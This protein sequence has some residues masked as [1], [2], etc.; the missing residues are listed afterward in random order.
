MQIFAFGHSITQG[1]WDKE[2]GWVQRLRKKLDSRSLEKDDKYYEVYNLGVSGDFTTDLLK[3]F[4]PE[5]KARLWEEVGTLIILQIGANDSIY[6]SDKDRVAVPEEDFRQNLKQL[7]DEAREYTDRLLLVGEAFTTIEGPIPWAE[8]KEMSDGRLQSYV[9][10]QREV[11][12][13]KDVELIDLR[14]EFS[15]SEWEELMED[16]VHPNSE[17]HERIFEIVWPVV[18]DAVEYSVV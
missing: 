18:D 17:G 6:L 5:I 14:K 1:Y 11:C 8:E 10:I 12:R 13:Q 16:G 2:G 9:E 4:Q 15:K 7:I 3:R